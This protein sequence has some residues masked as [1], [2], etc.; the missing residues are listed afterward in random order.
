M[1]RLFHGYAE[2]KMQQVIRIR[3]GEP[4]GTF[5]LVRQRD[6]HEMAPFGG[7]GQERRV[8]GAPQG[9]DARRESAGEVQKQRRRLADRRASVR[10]RKTKQH[11]HVP[12]A[13]RLRWRTAD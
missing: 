8:W 13:V 3:G 9:G 2:G 1:Q 4:R 5:E 7:C 12:Q 10:R 11:G 6:A